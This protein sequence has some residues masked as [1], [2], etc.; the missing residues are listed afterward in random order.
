MIHVRLVSSRSILYVSTSLVCLLIASGTALAQST[1]IGSVDVQGAGT[2]PGARPPI[3]SD[4]A[5]GSKAPPGSAPALAPAQGSLNAFE[6]GSVVSDKVIRDLI[7]PSSDYNETAK[8]TPGFLSNNANGLLGDSKSGWRGFQDGQFNITFDG[9]PFGDANDPTHHSSAYFPARFLGSVVV[10]R[11][12]GAASQVGYATFGGTLALSSIPLSNTFGGSI[13]A[14]YGSFSTFSS[15][16]TMQTGLIGD[17]GVRTLLQYSHGDTLGALQ[18]GKVNQDQFLAKI[19]KTVGDFRITVFTTYGQQQYNNVNPITYPQLQLYGKTY[20]EVNG[21]PKSQQFY[22]YNNSQKQTDMEYVR[23]EGGFDDWHIDNT[24]Y[25][26]SYWYPQMQ[27]NGADQTI[28]G[29]ASTANGGTITSVSIPTITGGKV[30]VAIK[31]VTNGDVVGYIKYNDYRAYGDIFKLSRD[32]DAGIA[33]GT[34]RFGI[35]FERVDNNRLQEYEDYTTGLTFPQLGNSTPAS[36]KLLLSSYIT[37]SQP[38][39]E[40]EW[41]PLERLSITPGF[42]FESFSRNHDAIINQTTLSPLYYSATYT[43]SMPFLAAR[44]KLTPELTVY[45]QA[46]KGFLAPTVSAYYVFDPQ[47]AGIQPQTTVNYQAGTVYKS[48]RITA[49]FDIYQVTADNFPITNT[50][51]TGET[52]YQNGGT[53]R[54]RGIEGEGSYSITNGLSVYASAAL[55][56][57]KYISGAFNDK[58]VGDAPDYTAAGGFIYDDG[59][60]FGSLLQKFTGGYYGSNGQKAPAAGTNTSL[61]YVEPY[62]TTDLVVGVRSEGLKQWL[63]VSL[64]KSAELK[65]GIY[66]IFDHQNIT[67][68]AGSPVGLTSINN[69]TLAYSFLPGRTI[70]GGLKVNF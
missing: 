28:E 57:A 46:S 21:N 49:D 39:I 40:Y 22:D 53:A 13:D 41:R 67:E 44:Y 10:D 6:P 35:W 4:A 37:N 3:A 61:N 9:I 64:P 45:A 11:G 26:Y 17:T 12:P 58:R 54:Y 66:N 24:A 70:F 38:F 60:F 27:N 5:I 56:Q 34:L 2:G 55:I 30:K 14:E 51:S 52:I 29:N 7:P 18:Y 32:V 50:L 36:Y 1:D 43:S 69:T 16:V 20:G 15:G 65:L 62:N 23:L 31:G 42:K 25:T 48:N 63:N 47:I 19:D 8:Y 68:I 33:S 59:M